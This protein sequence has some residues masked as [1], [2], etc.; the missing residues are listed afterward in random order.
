MSLVIAYP[1]VRVG[2]KFPVEPHIA[3]V[4]SYYQGRLAPIGVVWSSPFQ[5]GGEGASR[6]YLYERP[7][8]KVLFDRVQQG[9]HVIVPSLSRAFITVEDCIASYGMLKARGVTLH[10]VGFPKIDL[11]DTFQFWKTMQKELLMERFGYRKQTNPHTGPKGIVKV[12]YK[13]LSRDKTKLLP[14]VHDRA[15]IALALELHAGGMGLDSIV[16]LF[17]ERRVRT[18]KKKLWQRA[19]LYTGMK[20]SK[21]ELWTEKAI[22]LPE[23][24]PTQENEDVQDQE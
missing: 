13:V 8:G 7:A 15:C 14:D 9:D 3:A 23:P 21:Q 4:T 10:I 6:D 2:P 16:A 19:R 18:S 12:G 5:D 1:Y 11:L 17:R 22:V 20:L 24:K